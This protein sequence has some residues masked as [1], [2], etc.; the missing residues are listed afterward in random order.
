MFSNVEDGRGFKGLAKLRRI[1]FIF[2]FVIILPIPAVSVDTLI[3]ILF[4][5]VET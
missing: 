4:A 5:N 3:E 2:N 1:N